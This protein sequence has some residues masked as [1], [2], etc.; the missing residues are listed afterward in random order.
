M[1]REQDKKFLNFNNGF[2][3][4]QIRKKTIHWLHANTLVLVEL[5]KYETKNNIIKRVKTGENTYN[6]IPTQ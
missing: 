6:H 5:E 4:K 1:R 2:S 3:L